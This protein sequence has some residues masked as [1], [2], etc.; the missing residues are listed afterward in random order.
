MQVSIETC[1]LLGLI[2]D[3]FQD[4]A[5]AQTVATKFRSSWVIIRSFQQMA[6]KV[7]KRGLK[8]CMI[9]ENSLDYNIPLVE[10]NRRNGL[11]IRDHEDAKPACH[12]LAPY[13][14]GSYPLMHSLQVYT[15]H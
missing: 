13:L 9:L 7:R 15:S 4:Y 2:S 12:V 14:M 6:R 5:T 3:L 8:Q 1:S 11:Q 10:G